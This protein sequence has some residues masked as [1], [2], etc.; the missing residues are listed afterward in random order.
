PQLVSVSGGGRG[1][2]AILHAA[3]ARVVTDSDP[4]V[5]GEVLEIYGTGLKDGSVIPPQVAIGG[6][7]AQVLFFGNAP[8][9][10]GLNQVNVRVPG[11]VTPGP[12]VP[13]R[14]NYLGRFSNAV[15][16]GVQ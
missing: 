1:Q 7:L 9:F 4:G 8:G 13:V 12:E 15:S 16:I 6:R 11:G 10:A 5:P 3:S 14:L 2:G